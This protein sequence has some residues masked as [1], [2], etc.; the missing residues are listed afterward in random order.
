M[1]NI[2]SDF[3]IMRHSLIKEDKDNLNIS[4]FASLSNADFPSTP[5]KSN[6]DKKQ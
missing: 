5:K 6:E 2:K 1:S 4:R 3:Y